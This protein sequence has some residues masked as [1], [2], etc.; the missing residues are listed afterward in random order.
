MDAEPENV[1]ESGTSNPFL[2]E[3]V[4]PQ[5]SSRLDDLARAEDAPRLDSVDCGCGTCFCGGGGCNC[6]IAIA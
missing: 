4:S 6:A 2:F 5:W 3:R 1:A